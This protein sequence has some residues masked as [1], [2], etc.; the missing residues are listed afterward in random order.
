MERKLIAI[1]TTALIVGI[2]LSQALIAFAE[3]LTVIYFFKY[4]CPKVNKS[5]FSG[6]EGKDFKS[7]LVLNI[8]TVYGMLIS[9]NISN[10][11]KVGKSSL[12]IVL[13]PLINHFVKILSF[14]KTWLILKIVFLAECSFAL[15]NA[16]NSGNYQMR[17]HGLL[18]CGI[19]GLF[20]SALFIFIIFKISHYHI[21]KFDRL[22]AFLAFSFVLLSQSRAAFIAVLILTPICLFRSEIKFKVITSVLIIFCVMFFMPQK[23]IT[24]MTDSIHTA[25]KEYKDSNKLSSIGGRFELWKAAYISIVET[26][27]VGTGY[28][29]FHKDL[30]DFIDTGKIGTIANKMHLHNIF[31]QPL[32]CAGVLGLIGIIYTLASLFYYQWIKKSNAYKLR[33]II[34]LHIVLT[35]MFDA[36][37]EHSRKI[38]FYCILWS[39]CAVLESSNIEKIKK[40]KIAV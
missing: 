30:D 33:C 19:D 21:H 34:I 16:I 37:F 8:V 11:W 23:Y 6:E 25:K 12:H 31:L 4:V 10:G 9:S 3:G 17:H 22:I 35:G 24:Y 1:I 27:G 39:L 2:F 20:S 28:G 40:N 14:D 29:D 32:M 38:L 18:Y 15:Y 26:K 36:H 7:I 13:M 5:W